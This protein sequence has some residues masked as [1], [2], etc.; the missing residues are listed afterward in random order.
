MLGHFRAVLLGMTQNSVRRIGEVELLTGAERR[1]LLSEWNQTD[2]AVA[3]DETVVDL[4]AR[5]TVLR[6]EGVAVEFEGRRATRAELAARADRIAAALVDAGVRPES[7]VALCVE[8][9]IDMVAAVLGILQAGA[10]YV[11]IDPALPRARIADM[12]AD[13]DVAAILTQ[14]SLQSILVDQPGRILCLDH[15]TQGPDVP[16]PKVSPDFVAYIIFTSGSTGRP[17]GVE[18]THRSLVNLLRSISRDPGFGPDDVMLAV[19]TLS[20]DIATAEKAVFDTLYFSA[21]KGR[22]FAFLPEIE[23]PAS[24]Q[25]VRRCHGISP[26]GPPPCPVPSAGTNPLP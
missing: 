18:I 21:R 15:L 24:S 7:R 20:F 8:R 25:P 11:P 22:R 12:L 1:Q 5:Q 16:P 9:S 13:A 14:D 17:K 19:T 10:A 3:D 26:S 6:P 4:L 23:L 2:R